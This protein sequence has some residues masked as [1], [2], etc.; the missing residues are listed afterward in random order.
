RPGEAR[1]FRDHRQGQGRVLGRE[2]P[3]HG[4]APVER[5]DEVRPPARALTGP[6]G[7]R[8]PGAVRL[9]AVVAR[10]AVAWLVHN[11][12]DSV[13]RAGP[14][15]RRGRY[16]PAVPSSGAAARRR[17]TS[18]SA[19]PAATPALSDWAAAAMGIRA[20]MSQR[21]ATSRDSPRPSEPTTSTS[22]PSA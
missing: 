17:A 19:I 16:P 15:D 10:R 22:G 1:P 8:L 11:A 5:L 20:R 12:N 2:A 14:P 4:E 9:P 21:C 18:C 6:P 3:D 7:S 13:A